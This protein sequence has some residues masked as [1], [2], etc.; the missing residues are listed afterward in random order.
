MG[1]TLAELRAAT[2]RAMGLFLSGTATAGSTRTLTD[3]NRLAEYDEKAALRRSL[4]YISAAGGAAPEG[5]ARLV[6]AY[7]GTYRMLTVV[8]AFSAAVAADDSYELYLAWLEMDAWTQVVNLAIRGAWPEVYE[9]EVYDVAGDGTDSYALPDTVE[10]LLAVMIRLTGDYAGFPGQVIPATAY[11]VTGTVGDDLYCRLVNCVP[12]SRYLRFLYKERYAELSAY[13]D[14]TELDVEYVTAAAAAEMYHTLAGQA[15]GQADAGRLSQL[16]VHWQGV[17]AQR[18][19][20]LAA[21]ITG[22]PTQAGGKQK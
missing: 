5:E 18:K 22:A 16:M 3:E 7:S 15:G 8:P 20:A 13:D 14:E 11:Q 19:A 6:G 1:K 12:S 4:L 10:E 9:R 17:A 2:A 21:G